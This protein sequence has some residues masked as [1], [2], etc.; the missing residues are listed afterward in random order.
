MID[1]VKL[2]DL[3]KFSLDPNSIEIKEGDKVSVSIV[4]PLDN[5]MFL[6]NV[7]GRLLTANF[8]SLPQL[9]R[10]TAEVIKTDPVL[11]LRLI[12]K[13]EK[14]DENLFKIKGEVLRFD[15][16]AVVEIL[17]RYGVR[18]D[19]KDLT[20]EVVKKVIRDS[21]IFYEHKILNAENFKDDV[22]YNLFQKNDMESVGQIT[23]LQV[24]TILAGLEAF[25]P[26]KSDDSDMEDLELMVKKGKQMSVIIKTHFSKIGD[27]LIYIRDTGYG[28]VD[29]VIKSEVD[30]SKEIGEMK[31]EGVRVT[32]KKLD[33]EEFEKVDPIK[34]A[35]G[36]IGSIG[37]LA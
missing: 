11:E 22:K 34:D 10:F 26:I 6:V 30:I 7:R 12:T 9:S 2:Q 19:P 16:K 21:G 28:L 5:G 18:I 33:K 27:T 20:S 31:I 13:D 14:I 3:I 36:N 15:K 1:G 29:C 35:V 4:K 32:W 8:Q 25:L 17:D 37:I 24:I 23:K